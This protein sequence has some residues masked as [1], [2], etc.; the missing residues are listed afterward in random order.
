[1]VNEYTVKKIFVLFLIFLEHLAVGFIS[2]QRSLN[3]LWQH[4]KDT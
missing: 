3:I 1:M 2:Y 4:L